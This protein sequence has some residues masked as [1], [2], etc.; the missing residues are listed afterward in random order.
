MTKKTTTTKSTKTTAK[1][2]TKAKITDGTKMLLSSDAE[3]SKKELTQLTEKLLAEKER[4]LNKDNDQAKYHLDKNELFDPVD[5]ASAN[6]QAS[7]ELRFRNR[8]NFYLKK[9]DK[10][11]GKIEKG[12]YGICTECDCGISFLR[13]NA[14]PTADLC[15]LC[16][17]E[18][19]TSE[20]NNFYQKKSK[21]LGK[22]MQ[23]IGSR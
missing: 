18:N 19:E 20:K 4:I 2:A 14:R 21:S 9:I 10:A 5:E 17:E 11:L 6:I 16:K 13:L 3:I 15:I 1:K 7:T 23:E 12:E 8:E 22:T